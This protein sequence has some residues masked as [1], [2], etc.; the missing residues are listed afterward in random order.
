MGKKIR[1]RDEQPG[2][3]FREPRNHF[4]VHELFDADPG[5]GMKKIWVRDKHTGSAT[6]S[7]SFFSSI[8]SETSSDDVFLL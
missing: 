8:I 5:S 1:I 4:K 6:L 7:F 3:Y 2:S